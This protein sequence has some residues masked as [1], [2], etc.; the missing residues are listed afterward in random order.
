MCK[1]ITGRMWT[2]VGVNYASWSKIYLDVL[3]CVSDVDWAG[4]HHESSGN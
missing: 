4:G 2:F 3:I 1:G